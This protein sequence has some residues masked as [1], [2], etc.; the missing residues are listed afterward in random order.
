LKKPGRYS[1][2]EI[3]GDWKILLQIAFENEIDDP[4]LK[5]V[6]LKSLLKAGNDQQ[7]LYDLS[8]SESNII[9]RGPKPGDI[10]VIVCVDEER[11]S[12]DDPGS[13]FGRF[14][15][16]VKSNGGK[17]A[18][19]SVTDAGRSLIEHSFRG[20]VE[21]PVIIPGFPSP[22]G[23]RRQMALKMLLNAHI[24]SNDGKIGRVTGKYHDKCQPQQ[25]QAYRKGHF[26]RY[27]PR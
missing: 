25:S 20:D 6:A 11:N 1:L 14:G 26:S 10:G 8:F 3:S 2:A 5:D 21:V 9:K 7:Y 27:A 13:S 18:V 22:I 15:S 4:Y 19:V 16:M 24:K 12:V 23:L 17:V